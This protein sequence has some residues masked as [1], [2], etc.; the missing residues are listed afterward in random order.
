VTRTLKTTAQQRYKDT[1]K[2]DGVVLPAME[3]HVMRQ[4]AT[5]APDLT[6]D[7]MHPSEMSKPNWCGRH[8]Y[9]RISGLP[10][11]GEGLANPSFRMSNAFSEGHTIHEKYQRWLWE[12]G[13]L[14]GMWECRECG[15][16]FGALSPTECQF[17][18]SERLTYREVALRRERI[19]VEGHSDGAVHKLDDWSGLIE[20]KSI[21]IQT[22]RFE[23][24]RLYNRYM[25]GNETLESLWWKIN[26]PFAS[27]LK[28]GQLYLWLAWPRYEQICFIYESKFNQATK[29]FVVTY[30]KDM[31][32]S[33]LETAKEVSQCLRVGM[34]PDRPIWAEDST[35]R[36]CRSCEYRRTCW[37]LGELD[38]P[39]KTNDSPVRV[40]RANSARR[41]R[42]LQAAAVRPA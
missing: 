20:V 32:A 26:R 39:T 28:Q 36:V 22:I 40:R 8:D 24:P 3:R 14:W 1:F 34:T 15:H 16:I 10:P 27:H 2:D 41:K 31:I 25:D 4:L 6:Q 19:K 12:M 17:C 29:E 23:A 11:E 33:I 35:G 7:Y 13:V 5:K 9:Y 37:D 18:R 30:N 38:E 21:G 42:T